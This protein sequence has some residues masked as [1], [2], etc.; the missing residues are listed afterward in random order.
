MIAGALLCESCARLREENTILVASQA[1][2]REELAVS[3]RRIDS[4]EARIAALSKNSR[5]SS[6]PP[7]SDIVKPGPSARKEAGRKIGGQP[8]HRRHERILFCEEELS[9]APFEHY[10]STCPCC[11]GEGIPEPEWEPKVLQH[12]EIREIPLY[13]ARRSIAIM[14][15]DAPGAKKS[16]MRNPL[17]S[18]RKLA[19]VGRSSP[20]SLHT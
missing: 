19:C 7:S 15:A 2:L 17:H 3:Q 6:K 5:N 11:G 10:A 1:Q 9:V 8:G 14:P 18:C 16:T 20:P 12:V 13:K 4:L